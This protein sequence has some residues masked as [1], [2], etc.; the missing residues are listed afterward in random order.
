M[1]TSEC[2]SEIS[3]LEAFNIAKIVEKVGKKC[4][5]KIGFEVFA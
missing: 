2:K 4:C 5:S 3:I 1:E